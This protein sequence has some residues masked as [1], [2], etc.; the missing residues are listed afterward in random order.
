MLSLNDTFS[1]RKM[2]DQTD[3]QPPA[4]ISW[5]QKKLTEK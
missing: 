3:V 5:K 4:E 1:L 2:W